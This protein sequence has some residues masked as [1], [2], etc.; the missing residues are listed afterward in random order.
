KVVDDYRWLEDFSSPEVRRFSDEEN[1]HARAILDH[2]PARD[3]IERRVKTLVESTSP[4]YRALA[5]RRGTLFALKLEPPKQQPFL[6]ALPSADDVASQ[7]VI[8]DPNRIDPSGT[9]SI[10]FFV[11]SL[12]GK[13]VAVS[14]S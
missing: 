7:R 9:T 14:L 6:I 4:D 3:A 11:P 12:D 5:Y 2:L 1:R 10:D 8:V 13:R